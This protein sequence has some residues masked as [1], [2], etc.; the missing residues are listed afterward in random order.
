ML[1]PPTS[2]NAQ[3]GTYTISNDSL[4]LQFGANDVRR[5]T[6]QGAG[7]VYDPDAGMPRPTPKP[8]PT[9][10]ERW[11]PANEK[12]FQELGKELELD[13]PP[14]TPRPKQTFYRALE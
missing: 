2:E 11:T 3:S 10:S 6:V 7:F 14:A 9:Y 5:L 8:K 12:R 1:K 13:R 4:Y